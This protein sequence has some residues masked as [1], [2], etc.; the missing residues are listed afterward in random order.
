MYP[1]ESLHGHCHDLFFVR[2][3]QGAQINTS[4]LS[5][6]L[7]HMQQPPAVVVTNIVYV[8]MQP[9]KHGRTRGSFKD[10]QAN[11]AMPHGRC[12]V[13]FLGLLFLSFS[14]LC[15]NKG[16]ARECL[17]ADGL[18]LIRKGSNKRPIRSLFSSSVGMCI[19]YFSGYLP[20]T[21]YACRSRLFSSRS[22]LFYFFVFFFGGHPSLSSP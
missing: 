11:D 17:A 22:S 12:L 14:V 10:T 5:A 4:C 3:G 7:A 6:S 18:L 16:T 8:S 19:S 13:T 21:G 20:A 2:R 1:I 9:H 15:T